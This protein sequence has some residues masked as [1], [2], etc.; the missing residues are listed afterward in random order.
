[1]KIKRIALSL[2]I[3]GLSTALIVSCKKPS[4]EAP[5]ADTETE[6][7]V[8]ASWATFALTDIEQISAF[9][10]ENQP[11][12]HFYKDIPGSYNSANSTGSITAT[13]DTN[14]ASKN[15]NV[16]FNKSWCYDGHFREGTLFWFYNY[17]ADYDKF[18]GNNK[19]SNAR[20]SHDYG[21]VARIS[22][23]DYKVDGWQID[24]DNTKHGLIRAVVANLMPANYVA[25]N[26]PI[27][28]RFVG[29]FTF[30]HPTD[31]SK[32]MSVSVDLVKKLVN[33]TDK[34]I[35][36]QSTRGATINWSNFFTGTSTQPTPSVATTAAYVAYTGTV[37]GNTQNG[38]KFRMVIDSLH[39]LIRDFLCYADKIGGVTVTTT[40]AG[41]VP[42]Y[43]E[44]HP[45]IQGISSFTTG[46][47][48]TDIY[49]AGKSS[50]YPRQIYFGNEDNDPNSTGSC[51]NTGL[52]LIKG[53]G[54]KVDLRK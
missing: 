22:L 12:N 49:S 26:T 24:I 54:Y 41:I 34:K 33:S 14:G 32:N 20:Y 31:P 45:F 5:V 39:P 28:W 35:Y 8:D 25:A 11:L 47:D 1:M 48:A 50:I 51:D 42:R 16:A 44:F 52:V 30:T 36:D 3:L 2:T 43:Q 10:G 18:V 27:R 38:A 9:I 4:N 29:D 15:I 6:S 7:A 46:L 53:I 19:N 17:D 21:H 40:T 13:R 23:I 37:S